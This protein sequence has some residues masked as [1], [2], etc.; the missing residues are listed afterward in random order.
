LN[1]HCIATACALALTSVAA[2]QA[3]SVPNVEV[4]QAPASSTPSESQKKTLP[5]VVVRSSPFSMAPQPA[6]NVA[7][8]LAGADLDTPFAVTQVPIDL[9]SAQA[10]QSLQDALRN[11]PGA[12]ADSGFNGAQTQFFVLRGAI[13]DSG[14]GSNRILRDGVRLSNYPFVKAFVES[15][16]VLR[17]PGAALGLRSEPGGTVN[18]M[19][20]QAEMANFGSIRT[21]F[22]SYGGL[23]LSA[24]L[25]R[26]LSVED[27]LAARLILTRTAASEWRHQSDKL[28]GAR[29]SVS[30][31]DGD[32]YHLR[33]GAE[34]TYQVYR[35][36]YGIP[37]VNGSPIDVPRDR[38]YGEPWGDSTTE[39]RILDMHLDVAL[40]ADSRLNFDWTHLDAHSTSIKNGLFGN[41]ANPSNWA[42]FSS[43][44]PGTDRLIDSLATTLENQYRWGEYT[45]KLLWGADYYRETL[46]QPSY[47][48]SATAINVYD[49]V[50]GSISSPTSLGSVTLTRENLE[51]SA[52]SAQDQIEFGPWV[53]VAG[54]RYVQQDFMY[55]TAGTKSISETKALPKLGVLRKLSAE[56]SVYANY[57][58]GMAPNQV[59]S[60]STQSLASRY[61]DQ[62]E[63]GWKSLWN[64]GSLT[65][66]IAIY[67]L[68][69]RNM[70]ADDTSTA[71]RFDFTLDGRARSRG[72]EA[73]LSG[74][75]ARRV[76]VKLAYAYTH[77]LM[78]DH[79]VYA[80]GTTP[81]VA[82]HVLSLW[83]QY[84]WL[85]DSDI[86]WMTG[87]G[88]YGQTKRYA[89][90]ANTTEL[91]GY[92]RFDVTQTWQKP[93]GGTSSVEFQLAIRNVTD[94]K[95]YVSSH[96]HTNYWIMPGEGRNVWLT[97]NYR[98]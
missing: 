84:Q 24:D 74:E 9:V 72:L 75:V 97:M 36:D 33:L 44:E 70:I 15:V 30:K 23:E 21:S 35:P 51:S 86:K 1:K 26:V 96:L 47:S 61:S 79:P 82:A 18:L 45:H 69:Q 28:D 32:R 93:L 80:D 43:Y 52:L 85:I 46:N 66:D 16:D 78:L 31:S 42:R 81:N 53:V 12:Q 13:P 65:S 27:E 17:G 8:G 59:S 34:S 6:K 38:Q 94:T 3:Q 2:A 40:S 91:P 58:Q 73:S 54:L 56:D 25:N 37:A 98:F 22:G 11:V 49:P 92:A 55:G 64:A 39:N 50:Y 90:R 41:A 89:D 63:L 48:P 77:S 4:P 87:A 19:S 62:I 83:G 14:T 76:N 88:V 7:T 95:Y 71:N 5:A 57:A 29:V 20:K 10:G 60:S 67:Q 68:D